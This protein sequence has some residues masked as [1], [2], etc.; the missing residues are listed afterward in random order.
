M[1]VAL[2]AAA[3]PMGS[4]IFFPVLPKI[5]DE[6]NTTPTITNL[7]V[8]MYML[9]MAIFPLWW[10]SYSETLG[11]R[12]IY[13]VSFILFTIASIA[14][15]VSTSIG[16]LVVFRIIA[17]GAAASVQAVGAGTI[18]DLWEVYER[19]RAMGIFY[20]GPLMGPLIA[21]ILAGVLGQKLG[22]RSTQWALTIY[23]VIIC[24]LL[25][26]FVPETLHRRTPAAAKTT[27]IPRI[28]T[29]DFET[30]EKQTLEPNT[31]A[32]V[33][34]KQSTRQSVKEKTSK[35]AKAMR[36]FWIEPWKP[37]L[38][39]RF[40][41]VVIIVYYA[42]ITFGALYVLS[43]SIQQTFSK[44]PY[45]FSTLII[46]LLYIPSALGYIIA[47]PF[48]GKWC[49]HIMIREAKAAGRY[50]E[51][52][53]LIFIPEDRMRE[54]AYIAAAMYP[55]ALVLYGWAAKYGL[56]WMVAAVANF[57]FGVGSMVIFS[58]ATTMLTEFMP[59][60]S[61]SGVA[62]N[63]LVRNVFAAI[64][65]VVGAPLIEKVGNGWLFTFLGVWC[66]ASGSVVW[67]MRRYG[68]GWRVV[69]QKA[70]DK[71]N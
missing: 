11:R 25:V 50:D 52:G 37:M 22:W 63:N 6:F 65:G 41:A 51:N 34:T 15:A 19:G 67:A 55:C 64:G 43:V 1:T 5:A 27:A 62:L 60:R 70:M 3:A 12:T 24:F 56:H 18:A 39:L 8:A 30:G 69:M 10:S 44:P 2:A 33:M 17:G 21:P 57:F 61:S 66:F 40:P 23:G 42:A 71:E 26:C 29:T 54:N 31:L 59:K 38:Y 20:L 9:A 4:A 58:V 36:R 13:L 68:P 7:S 35:F 46:G 45:N 14:S 32:R 28:A 48:G 47:S 53:K 49:D 16:M